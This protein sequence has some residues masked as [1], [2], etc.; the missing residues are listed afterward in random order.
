MTTNENTTAQH[1]EESGVIY[2]LFLDL[3][4]TT[5]RELNNCETTP[6][7][8]EAR[9]KFDVVRRFSRI[10]AG[11]VKSIPDESERR[12]CEMQMETLRKEGIRIAPS[13]PYI[14]QLCRKPWLQEQRPEHKLCEN[15]EAK[16]THHTEQTDNPQEPE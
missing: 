5:R 14:C 9:Y 12:T 4:T 13:I 2:E 15:C 8:A 3:I 6:D 1:P 16:E 7:P 11:Q 10:L